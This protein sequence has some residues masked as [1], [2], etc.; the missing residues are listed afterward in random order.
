MNEWRRQPK[1]LA[2]ITQS[3]IHFPAV[4]IGMFLSYLLSHLGSPHAKQNE[5]ALEYIGTKPMGQ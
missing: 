2:H 3:Q 4:L 1:S 5:T